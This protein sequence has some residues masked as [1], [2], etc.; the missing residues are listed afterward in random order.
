MSQN[1]NSTDSTQK[2]SDTG[3]N[4]GLA[5]T[6]VW[7]E[8]MFVFN[9]SSSYL[10][11]SLCSQTSPSGP[12]GCKLP[13][14]QFDGLLFEFFHYFFNS[15]HVGAANG[16]VATGGTHL[17]AH[18]TL[19]AHEAVSLS[20]RCYSVLPWVQQAP[21]ITISSWRHKH[22][23]LTLFVGKCCSCHGYHWVRRW[24]DFKNTKQLV[25]SK[26]IC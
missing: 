8:Q 9:S 4:P 21:V 17:I 5:F 2:E 12:L 1:T 20:P 6:A 14:G 26:L 18:L 24:A 10:I 16:E 25:L 11:R 13:H 3:P 19:L 23:K 22:W 15:W 7:S